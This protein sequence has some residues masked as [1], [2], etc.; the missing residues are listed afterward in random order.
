MDKV[1]Y[2][3]I[4]NVDKLGY[5]HAYA[6]VGTEMTNAERLDVGVIAFNNFNDLKEEGFDEEDIEMMKNLNIGQS[7]FTELGWTMVR[8]K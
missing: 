1:L 4:K 7:D 6:Y 5:K 2:S 8:I 3:K